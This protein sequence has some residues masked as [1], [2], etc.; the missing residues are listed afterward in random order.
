M[1]KISM[2]KLEFSPIGWSLGWLVQSRTVA[3]ALRLVACF[4]VGLLPGGRCPGLALSRLDPLCFASSI[5]Q[6]HS[7]CL[8]E[9]SRE[10]PPAHHPVGPR[11]TLSPSSSPLLH[12]YTYTIRAH[13]R[14]LEE[15]EGVDSASEGLSRC[16]FIDLRPLQLFDPR[17][18]PRPGSA[19]GA[20]GKASQP[21]N[22]N[23]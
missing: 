6:L 15:V 12:G 1:L 14:L 20:H 8:V 16:R 23:T 4:V 21:S 3:H 7:P 2:M 10:W 17:V 18:G 13:R 5:A 9:A 22:F 11:L 19:P